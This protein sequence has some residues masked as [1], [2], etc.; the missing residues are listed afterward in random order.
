MDSS[1]IVIDSQEKK[2]GIDSDIDGFA[3]K[4]LKSDIHSV[5]G[6]IFEVFGIAYNAKNVIDPSK[7][8]VA[9][10]SPELLKKMQTNDIQFLRDKV[11]DEI[12][13]VLYDYTE[14]G[15]GG[16]V[17]LEL[18]GEVSRQD[19]SNL[20]G[21]F[22]NLIEQK[23]YDDLSEQLQEIFLTVKTIE[24]GQQNDR[25]AEVISGKN[26]LI[27][28][29]SVEDDETV[30][31]NLIANAISSLFTGKEKIERS[32]CDKLDSLSKVPSS[33]FLQFIFSLFRNKYI[34]KRKNE[35][36]EIQEL[37]K[38]YCVALSALAYGYTC[39]N[40]S[41]LI[42]TLI[43]SCKNVFEHKKLQALKPYE[44]LIIESEYSELDFDKIWY[45]CPK[46]YENDLLSNNRIL[47]YNDE[48]LI[49]FTGEE[50]LEVISNEK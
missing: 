35:Y 3:T 5:L 50:I 17:R 33:S 34:I 23:R 27:S 20:F 44:S 24:R 8:Y 40:Q 41:H 31:K 18:K 49:E 15:F 48:V 13:P 1:R 19:F 39:L 14:K 43:I 46:K 45:S 10:F 6:N 21:S 11:T 28:A 7:V 38:Y 47:D 16:Q 12:L 37:F 4:K 29:L 9:K 42:D 30:K 32:L 26:Q 25:I 2:N 36:E 22:S